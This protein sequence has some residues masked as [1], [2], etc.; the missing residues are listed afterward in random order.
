MFYDLRGERSSSFNDIPSEKVNFGF[1]HLWGEEKNRG[2]DKRAGEDQR[3][4][5]SQA[6]QIFRLKY[7]ACQTAILWGVSL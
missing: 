5:V 3:D 6:F 2:R 1:L 7:S 4:L